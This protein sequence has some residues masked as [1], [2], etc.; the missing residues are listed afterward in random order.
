VPGST[1]VNCSPACRRGLQLWRPT[2]RVAELGSLGRMRTARKRAT[3]SLGEKVGDVVAVALGED[4]F[5][6]ISKFAFGHGILPFFSKAAVLSSDPLPTVIPEMF[7]D[8]W[9]YADDPTPMQ[10]VGSFPF[11]SD[12]ESWGEPAFE[13]PD[14]IEPC[15]KIHD[16]FNSIA[17]IIKPATEQQILGVRVLQ[18]YQPGQFGDFLAK[19]LT[20]WPTIN[21]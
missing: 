19:Y 18:R 14:E 20:T 5:C 15:F 8:V 21:R 7:F 11:E 6:Y 13:P 10:F 4:R 1:R 2:G 17:S 3:A 16:V 9:V 12:E